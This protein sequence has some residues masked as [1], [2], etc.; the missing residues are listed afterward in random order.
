MLGEALT[1]G[2]IIITVILLSITMLSFYVSR[3]YLPT[4]IKSAYLKSITVLAAAVE[5]RESGT[6]GHAQR[7]AQL[8]VEVARRLGLQGKD[9]ERI[10]YAALLMDMG[11]ANVPQRLLSK[12]D[13]LTLDEWAVIQSHPRLGA[14]MVE[15]VP[16]VA[17]LSDIILHHHEYWDGTGYPNGM[18]GE[19]IPL[20]SRILGVTADYDA[21][22]SERPYHP[23]PLSHEEAME[24]IRRG[25]GWRYDPKVAEVFL[26]MI[27]GEHPEIGKD[28]KAA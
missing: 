7:V 16:F 28:D 20:E 11:K 9:L 8:T 13:R 2:V 25:I 26:E 1:P 17:D 15:A 24:E 18:S 14:E 12:Q 27:A 6:V 22:V 21:M 4:K 3:Y 5:T 23:R 10:E 19:D